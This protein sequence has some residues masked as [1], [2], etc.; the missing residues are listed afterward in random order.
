L[1]A[2]EEIITDENNLNIYQTVD[3]GIENRIIKYINE[4]NTY[5]ELIQNIKTKRYTYNKISRMLLH[6]LTSFTKEE[7][8][9]IKVEYIRILG[10]SYKGQTYL[11]K[12]KK[13]IEIP[14]ITTFSNIKSDM[15]DVEFR[16]TC[17]YASVLN[18]K[19]KIKLIESEYKNS[20]IIR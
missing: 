6:I 11:N 18:E 16:T 13:E 3:E 7:A 15:L 20:P 8:S 14:I 4:S 10:F 17:V 9:N 1:L 12:I 5:E 19:D 2:A